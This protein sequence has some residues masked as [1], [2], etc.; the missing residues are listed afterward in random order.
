MKKSLLLPFILLILVACASSVPGAVEPTVPPLIE[1]TTPPTAAP[2]TESKTEMMVGD[3][4]SAVKYNLGETTIVQ[5]R[6]PED[7]RFH[8]MPVRLNGVLAAP[9]GGDGP[10]PV[11]VIFHGTH[12]GCPEQEGGVDRWPCDPE[13]EQPNYQGFAYLV[14]ALAAEGYVAIA[15]NFNAE[16]TFGFGEGTPGERLSQLV[17]LHL[18]AMAEAA[19]G[20]SNDFGVDLDGR[21]DVSRMVF[22]GH[23]RGGEASQ[24][25]D[26]Q[27]GSGH[28]GCHRNVWLRASR[29]AASAGPGTD[30]HSASR[31]PR[32]PGRDSSGLRWGRDEPGRAAFL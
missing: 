5:S 30:L 9:S 32:A 19:D 8:D 25:V 27:P 14:E 16:N 31:F 21:A 20:G 11:V 23:S 17:K 12:P 13:V 18:G 22:F 2:N 10:Y 6:F 3:L 15:P 4:P 29:R 24:L 26:Q 1:S 7:S 28:A